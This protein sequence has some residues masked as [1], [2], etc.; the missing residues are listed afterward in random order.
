MVSER[1]RRRITERAGVGVPFTFTSLDPVY[2]RTHDAFEIDVMDDDTARVVMTP[3]AQ[4]TLA[5]GSTITATWTAVLTTPPDP[6]GAGDDTIQGER[7]TTQ[8]AADPVVTC[9]VVMR[10]TPP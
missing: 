5:E 8:S 3:I 7:T 2:A 1:E 10:G 4:P 9:S 6:G